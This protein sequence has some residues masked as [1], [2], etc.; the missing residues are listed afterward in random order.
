MPLWFQSF[1]LQG[2]RPSNALTSRVPGFKKPAETQRQLGKLNT[3][4]V[5]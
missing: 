4:P 1:K 5:A 2:D 3:N